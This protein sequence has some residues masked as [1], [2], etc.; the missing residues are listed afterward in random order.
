MEGDDVSFKK[1]RYL[2]NTR[3]SWRIFE[4]VVK[5]VLRKWKHG[6]GRR[7]PRGAYSDPGERG[8]EF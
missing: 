5:G 8:Y 1:V 4:D 3:K 6:L 2:E 7:S